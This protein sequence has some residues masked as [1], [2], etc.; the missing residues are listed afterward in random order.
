[1]LE[2]IQLLKQRYQT[3]CS[4]TASDAVKA[5]YQQ[6]IDRQILAEAS[7]R[8]AD[9]HKRFTFQP[10]QVAVVGPTQAGKSTLVNLLLNSS[11]AG[12][13]PLAGFTVHA[14]G[15]C[16]SVKLEDCESVQHFFGRF[17]QVRQDELRKDRLECYALTENIGASDLL[18]ECLVWDTPDFDSIGA[19]GY[20]EALMRS[21]ALADIV[22]LVVSKEKYADQSVW[23]LMSSI[24]T[25]RQPTLICVNKLAEGSEHIVIRSLSEKWRQSRSDDCPTIVPLFYQKQ[26]APTWPENE[27]SAVRKLFR[28]VNRRRNNEVVQEFLL[29]HWQE[30]LEPVRS[31]HMALQEWRSL[32]DASIKQSLTQYQNDYL[33]HPRYYETFQSALAKLLS[34]LEIPGFARV[35]VGTRKALTWP[36]RQV[37]KIGMKRSRITDSSHEVALLNHLAEH[38]LI[39][40]MDAL[41]EKTE[42]NGDS[43]WWRGGIGLLRNR[44]QAL[45]VEFNDA[46]LRYHNDFQQE[47]ESAAFRLYA[48]LQEQPYVLNGLRAT[49]ATT[50]AAAVAISIQAGG[51]G[52]HDLIIAPAM[53][54]VTS[55][56]TE[57]AMGSYLNKVEAELKQRQLQ[58]VRQKL[59]IECLR[60][61]LF[62]LPEQLSSDS[63]FNITPEQL[64]QAEQQL[65]NKKHGLR[66]L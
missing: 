36:I 33:N 11:Q 35:L 1:M 48:K 50:D 21:I 40:I 46:V 61:A 53:L 43:A 63:Y 45:L 49:R 24:E 54:S 51:L 58:I 3:V 20:S 59:Y 13:S 64:E 17:Q 25:L 14:Q 8:K 15:F 32:V 12:V 56:L 29:K 26:A 16:N 60:E 57:S 2:F 47:V 27:R 62:K 38:L 30:W 39:R 41:L 19:I 65:K 18:P 55:F 22:I 37:M 9:M 34:L 7:I 42:Q 23:E 28:Q 4:H 31:E 10:L 5:V 66:L 44:R 52:L 6:R